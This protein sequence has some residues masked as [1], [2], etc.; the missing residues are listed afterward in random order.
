MG[1]LDWSGLP[2]LCALYSITDVEGLVHRLQVIKLH[3]PPK[4]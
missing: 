1:G 3:R 4:E 2:F